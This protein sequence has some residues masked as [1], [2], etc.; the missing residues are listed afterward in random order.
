MLILI[1]FWIIRKVKLE[2]IEKNL[3]KK[4]TKVGC[5]DCHGKIGAEKI[6]S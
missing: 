5:I 2:E 3:G 4:L 1:N 6:G